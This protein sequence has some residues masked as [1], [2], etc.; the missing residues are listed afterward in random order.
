MVIDGLKVLLL[1]AEATPKQVVRDAI[2]SEAPNWLVVLESDWASA[3]TRQRAVEV[4]IVAGRNVAKP[5][6][7]QVLEVTRASL[8]SV[9]LL[10]AVENA[11]VSDRISALKA[12]AADVLATDHLSAQEICRRIEL[13]CSSSAGNRWQSLPARAELFIDVATETILSGGRPLELTR[14]QRRLLLFLARKDGRV[15]SAEELSIHA[16]IQADREQKNLRNQI[17]RLRKR[18]GGEAR[19]LETVEGGYRLS[20]GCLQK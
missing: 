17:W 10:A 3:L 8:G 19:F 6:L 12:G 4:I 16:G 20:P 1:G 14:H 15:V 2:Q 18:L 7:A 9:P 11:A 5:A 13:A